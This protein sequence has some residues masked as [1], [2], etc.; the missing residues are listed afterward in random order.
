[1]TDWPQ[2]ELARIA[3][4]DDL[5]VAPLR[6]DGVMVGTPTWIW[7]VVLDGALYARA[8]N[9]RDSRWHKAALRQKAGRITAGGMTREVASSP[10]RAPSTTRSTRPTA[11]NTGAVPI[12]RR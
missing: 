3:A 5:H 4:S 9:G 6:D 10:S 1:M 7:S 12:L 11:R 8:Y 2:K